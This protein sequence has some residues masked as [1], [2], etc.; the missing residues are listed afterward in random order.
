MCWQGLARASAVS[1]ACLLTGQSLAAP[2]RGAYPFAGYFRISERVVSPVAVQVRLSV[3]LHNLSGAEVQGATVMLE[4]TQSGG[5]AIGSLGVVDIADGASVQLDGEFLVS[6]AE[7]DLWRKGRS[8]RLCL[9]SG[10]A[11]DVSAR[12]I[13]LMAW[14]DR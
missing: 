4:E 14:P 13:E 3:T 11:P 5:R 9:H 6:T 12:R 10:A 7:Y 2:G 8:P 1:L